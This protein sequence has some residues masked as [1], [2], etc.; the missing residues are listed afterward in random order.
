MK[1]FVALLF[2]TWAVMAI[3]YIDG[4]HSVHQTCSQIVQVRAAPYQ[5]NASE[6]ASV[7]QSGT[8]YYLHV[9]R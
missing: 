5:L 9:C 3:G 8:R 1:V 4:R 2:W 7:R 6:R